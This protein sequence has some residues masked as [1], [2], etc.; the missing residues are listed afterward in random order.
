M[1]GTSEVIIGG[2]SD[3]LVVPNRAVSLD[4][5]TRSSIVK[6]V[7]AD[8]TTESVSVEV[9]LRGQ[10]LTEIRGGLALGD[11]IEIAA[12]TT[13]ASGAQNQ[14]GGFAIPGAGGGFPGGGQPGR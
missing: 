3:V 6:R 14:Q 5:A 2:A 1:S 10:T 9:G 8:G 12:V 7:K 4:R 11:Q 13:G